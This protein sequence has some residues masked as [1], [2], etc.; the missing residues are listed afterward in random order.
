MLVLYSFC[1]AFVVGFTYLFEV[2]VV[3]LSASTWGII[4]CCCL[5][6]GLWLAQY[7]SRRLAVWGE[8]LRFSSLLRRWT[9]RGSDVTGF[10]ESGTFSAVLEGEAGGRAFKRAVPSDGTLLEH[11]QATYRDLDAEDAAAAKVREEVRREA[12]LA[13]P[14]LGATR[15]ERVMH[16]EA[17]RGLFVTA[18]VLPVGYGLLSVMVYLHPWVGLLAGGVGIALVVVALLRYRGA[19]SLQWA[20]SALLPGG[21]PIAACATAVFF[22]TLDYGQGDLFPLWEAG[23]LLAVVGGLGY[24]WVSTPP[25]RLWGWAVISL[26]LFCVG[27]AGGQ[28]LDGLV[29]PGSPTV[30]TTRVTDVREV[31]HTGSRGPSYYTYE[32]HFGD[33]DGERVEL[34]INYDTYRG[35]ATGDTIIVQRYTGLLGF[36]SYVAYDTEARRLN[37]AQT[38]LGNIR[39]WL[40]D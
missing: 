32:L 17:A 36:Y 6:G 15:E 39:Y 21:I 16:Y 29:S 10:R 37:G 7:S 26:S 33:G 22:A 11:L 12:M 20:P 19:V 1:V 23:L 9:V 2:H 38:L 35:M 25:E 8:E 18:M 27:N 30:L 13:D 24:L 40:S 14:R 28:A 31:F 34:P 4:V 5:A 3:G